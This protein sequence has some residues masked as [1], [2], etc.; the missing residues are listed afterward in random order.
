MLGE[1]ALELYLETKFID[2]TIGKSIDYHVP[3]LSKIG[4]NVGIKTVE[5]GKFLVI[6]KNSLSPEIIMIKRT[7]NTVLLCGLATNDIL[8]KYQCDDLIIDKK[9]R[10]KG[11]K[12]AFY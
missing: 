8:N 3:D 4:L 9:L 1:A 10:E 7:R 6:F 5:W 11:S 12:T 2:W